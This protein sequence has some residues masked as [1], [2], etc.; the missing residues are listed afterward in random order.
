MNNL[1]SKASLNKNNNAFVQHQPID[2]NNNVNSQQTQQQ[3]QPIAKLCAAKSC[4]TETDNPNVTPSSIKTENLP[5]LHS[6]Q[7]ESKNGTTEQNMTNIPSANIT[8]DQELTGISSPKSDQENVTNN[9]NTLENSTTESSALLGNTSTPND[10]LMNSSTSQQVNETKFHFDI[11]T[12]G[13]KR[14]S[15]G[16]TELVKKGILLSYEVMYR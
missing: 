7:K 2:N 16:L 13:W 6:E 5:Q 9:N 10:Q 14:N 1:D 11:P 8:K 4:V 15:I 3:Q 12:Y